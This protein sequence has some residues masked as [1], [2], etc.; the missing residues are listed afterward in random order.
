MRSRS[1]ALGAESFLWSSSSILRLKAWC[2]PTVT[3][4]SSGFG[5]MLPCWPVIEALR[6][7]IRDGKNRPPVHDVERSPR[8]YCSTPPG[9]AWSAMGAMMI[10]YVSVERSLG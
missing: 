2:V 8:C 9:L 5:S 6:H 4:N 1:D 10:S 7:R 3:K